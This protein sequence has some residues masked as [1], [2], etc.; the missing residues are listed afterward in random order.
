MDAAVDLAAREPGSIS[1]VR[2]LPVVAV[3]AT[4]S[5][6]AWA[7]AF[8]LAW[9]WHRGRRERALP[10]AIALA[11]LLAALAL[12]GLVACYRGQEPET[13]AWLRFAPLA[14]GLAVGTFVLV[15]ANLARVSDRLVRWI[16]LAAPLAALELSLFVWVWTRPAAGSAPAQALALAGFLAAVAASLVL[17]RRAHRGATALLG[18][19]FAA[20]CA[21]GLAGLVPRTPETARA[22][23]AAPSRAVRRIVLVVV[24][25]LRADRLSCYSAEA[26][27]TPHIDALAAE[28]IVFEA[29]RASA[30]FTLP[31]VCTILTG[32]PPTVHRVRDPT[33]A[34]PRG[35]TTLAERLRAE[36]YRTAAFVR[37]PWLR[38]LADFDRGFEEFHF[39]SWERP[40]SAL[41]EILLRRLRSEVYRPVADGGEQARLARRWIERHR[42]EDFFLWLHFLDPHAPYAPPPELMP[43]GQPPPRI[44]RSFRDAVAVRTGNL[45]PDLDERDWIEGLYGGEVRYLDRCV[46]EITA[47]MKRLG[48]YD[49]ALIVLTSDHGEEFWEHGGFEHGQSMFDELLRVPLILRLPRAALVERVSAPVSHPSLAPTLLSLCGIEYDPEEFPLPPLVRDL[50]RPEVSVPAQPLLSSM[51]LYFEDRTAVVFD[52]WKYVRYAITGREELYD[53]GRDPRETRELSREAPERLREAREVLDRELAGAEALRARLALEAAAAPV[54]EGTRRGLRALGYAK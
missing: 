54:D 28:G 25:T 32:V 38:P 24:D 9:P 48:I 20:S 49:D 46:G 26:P 8:A 43:P 53:L 36:G 44:G 15:R 4:A 18:I 52:G 47:E 23:G 50:D 16:A 22:S 3:T 19:V 51:M 29:A 31:S 10:L 27:P 12:P 33:D 45:V 2:T 39:L 34:L 17:A 13:A 30:P 11:A 41:A 6:L 1:P 35:L 21:P 42:D 40:P 14:F 37:N 5:L 7:L